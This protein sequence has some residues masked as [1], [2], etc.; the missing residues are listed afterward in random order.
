MFLNELDN[1][2]AV[3]FVNIVN[4]FAKIDNILAKE[5]K[6][7]V[8][9]YLEE[10]KLTQEEI[11]SLNHYEAMEVFV[12][13]SERIKSIVYFELV[14]LALV[15]GKYEDEEV[16]FLDEIAKKLEISRAKRIAFANYFFNFTEI[17]KFSVI[18]AES[19]IKLLREEAEKL[20]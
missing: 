12:K 13:S 2:Q 6:Y 9:D 4:E 1:Y 11:G 8:N 5:E 18:D 10:L 19:K 3:A 14:G 16:D 7:L 20:L 17:Y 15:D